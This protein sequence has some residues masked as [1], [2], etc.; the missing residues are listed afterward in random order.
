MTPEKAA[1]AHY[2]ART[3]AS[4]LAI[5]AALVDCDGVLYDSM[6]HHS[7]AWVRLLADNGIACTC[8]EFYQAEGMVG[9]EIIKAKIKHATGRTI[10]N[11]EAHALYK[12]KGRYFHELGEV[13][14]I[15]GTHDVLTHLKQRGIASV[16][17][18]GSQQVSLLNR[19]EI[20]YPG[21]FGNRRVTGHDVQHGKP[22]PEPY[23]KGADYA[24]VKPHEC[25]VLE[26]A[27]LGIQSAHA[28]GCFAIGIN[29]GP[30]SNEDLYGAGADIVYPDM[31]HLLAALPNLLNK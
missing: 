17:V 10:T 13:A 12:V 5:K 24:S 2:L 31:A 29:T 27:P 7:L 8:D 11:E 21:I 22:H 23:L 16:L 26:N 3:G 1:I 20:D 6:K 19:I 9:T 4:Q 25:I 30:L 18:T 28:A 14:M 15:P